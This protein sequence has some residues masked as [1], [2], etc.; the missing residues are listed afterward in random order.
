M[1]AIIHAT[2][3]WARID[4]KSGWAHSITT[5]MAAVPPGYFPDPRPSSGYVPRESQQVCNQTSTDS[6]QISM[7]KSRSG[8][9]KALPPVFASQVSF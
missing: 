4:M 6:P 9:Q 8:R 2:P 3:L 5:G 1:R 7:P